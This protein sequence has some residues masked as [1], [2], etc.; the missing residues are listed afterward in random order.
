MLPRPIAAPRQQS[1][2]GD[3]LVKLVPEQPA[4]AFMLTLAR[5]SAEPR[6]GRGYQTSGTP[7]VRPSER[8]TQKL[9]SWKRTAIGQGG[10]CGA[11]KPPS[12]AP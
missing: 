4:W 2:D 10:E 5:A 7:S 3:I 6:N 11:I 9:S 12:S 1:G 8:S